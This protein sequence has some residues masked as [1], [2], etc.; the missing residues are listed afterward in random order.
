MPVSPHPVVTFLED[1]LRGD[2]LAIKIHAYD[3]CGITEIMV[4]AYD[5]VE[6]TLANGNTVQRPEAI[7]LPDGSWIGE[8]KVYDPATKEV[9]PRTVFRVP[10]AN[11]WGRTFGIMVRVTT[12]CGRQASVL[13]NNR[14]LV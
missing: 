5:L 2:N 9:P 1:N 4:Y 8:Q 6:I 14:A 11:L 7:L 10:T 3:P 12:A 13:R